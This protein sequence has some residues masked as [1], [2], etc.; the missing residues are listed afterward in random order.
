MK[1]DIQYISISSFD[2]GVV[3]DV[4]VGGIFPFDSPGSIINSQG[5]PVDGL[6]DIWMQVDLKGTVNKDYNIL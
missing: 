6:D 3:G 1:V 4:C 5:T 2:L